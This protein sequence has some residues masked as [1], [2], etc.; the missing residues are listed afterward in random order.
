VNGSRIAKA[1]IDT[2]SDA[3]EAS[4]LRQILVT[5][6]TLKIVGIL[7]IFDVGGL[8]AFDFPKSLF[9]RAFEW[10]LAGVLV[11]ALFR[12]GMGIV[13]R[14]RLHIVAVAFVLVYAVSALFAENTYIALY[15]DRDHYLGLTFVIDMAVLY[16]AVATGF[17]NRSDW[18]V[19]A[20]G[21]GAASLVVI[22]YAWLQYLQL[23]PIT[24]SDDP[25]LRPFSTF[26]NPDPLGHY[27]SLLFGAAVAIAV[28][29]GRLVSPALRIGVGVLCLLVLATSAVVATRGTLLA[30]AA[31]LAT[32][33][34][35]Q[36]RLSGGLRRAVLAAVV[37]VGAASCAAAL[38]TLTPLGERVQQIDAGVEPRLVFF[39][40]AARAFAD[41][42]LVGSGPDNFGVTFPRYRRPSDSRILGDTY[43]NSAHD[44]VLQAAATTG[45]AGVLAAIALVVASLWTLWRGTVGP[46]ALLCVTLFVASVAYWAHAFVAVGSVSVDWFPWL[47][48]GAAASTGTR[49]GSWGI[50]RATLF[51]LV[52][53]A[54]A[55]VCIAGVASGARAFA[56]NHDAGAARQYGQSRPAVARN[57]GEAAVQQDPGRA[58]YWNSLASA[59][60]GDGRWTDASFAVEEAVARA[61]HEWTYWANLARTRTRASN[62]LNDPMLRGALTAAEQAVAVDPNE[63]LAHVV[64]SE[65]A[66]AAQS[67]D[68]ALASAVTAILLDPTRDF[69]A[70]ATRPASRVTDLPRA[71]RL[72]E[73]AASAR[74]TAALH[75]AVA[76]TALKLGDITS[77]RSHARRALELSPGNAEALAVLRATGD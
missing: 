17:R 35:L 14:T 16:F 74:D 56:A 36:L 59:Y 72:L 55:A 49:V 54:S 2:A 37:M 30:L 18:A 62:G 10:L 63:P 11:V 5:L 48:L 29:G 50:R 64:L 47:V 42:P 22:A 6:V 44:W 33:P 66:F 51:K 31:A 71:R 52:A 3:F 32:L 68:I 4:P 28:V 46:R 67:F 70:F 69:D 75:A 73:S 57:A 13:P 77:A 21:V 40:A 60:A 53:A 7:L 12:H 1:P 15:G 41:R 34:L 65:T 58:E 39:D 43:N 38:L 27:L 26:G 45:T 23:D 76:Q 20:T 24:W 8:Q 19:V 9:S 61:P 25:A